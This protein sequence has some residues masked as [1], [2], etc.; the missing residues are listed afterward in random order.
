MSAPTIIDVHGWSKLTA[1][2]TPEGEEKWRGVRIRKDNPG[3]ETAALFA[4]S[5]N[6]ESPLVRVRAF[7]SGKVS[8]VRLEA[9]VEQNEYGDLLFDTSFVDNNELP[10]RFREDAPDAPASGGDAKATPPESTMTAPTTYNAVASEE[11]VKALGARMDKAAA[12]IKE[13]RRDIEDL[14]ESNTALE[15]EVKRLTD[16]AAAFAQ[17][18]DD[19]SY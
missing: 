9:L 12:V 3:H 11:S 6:M 15:A 16:A 14:K 13:M 7:K 8:G 18:E 5:P 2:Q 10:E 19:E 1:D 4:A 17:S